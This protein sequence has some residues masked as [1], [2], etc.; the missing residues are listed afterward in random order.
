[1]RRTLVLALVAIGIVSASAAGLPGKD[2]KPVVVRGVGWSPWHSTEHWGLSRETRDLDRRLLREAHINT[3]RHWGAGKPESVTGRLADGFY[4]IPTIHCREGA[5]AQF[6]DGSPK[7]LAFSDWPSVTRRP[8]RSSP[9]G[10]RSTRR[11]S[12]T[13]K[14]P[15]VS[16]SATSTRRS[17]IMPRSRTTS[18][19]ASS[20]RHKR[21]SKRGWQS[22]LVTSPNSTPPAEPSSRASTRSR[23]SRATGR[24]TSGGCSSTA[25]SSSSCARPTRP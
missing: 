18:T 21:A 3:L 25:P 8:E 24:A 20:P 4:S 19:P 7:G 15:C 13:A 23:P 17:G 22:G 12:G 14:A 10:S 5:P 2:G 16:S 9:S 1:M 11:S 6:P